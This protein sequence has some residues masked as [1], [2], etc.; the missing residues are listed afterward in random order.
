[1]AGVEEIHVA[2]A[3][4]SG[5]G[6]DLS[7]LPQAIDRGDFPF[8]S[9]GAL[10]ALLHPAPQITGSRLLDDRF[11]VPQHSVDAAIG[12]N[13]HHRIVRRVTYSMIR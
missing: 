10:A 12:E 8:C 7:F 6:P 9:D 5:S 13:W 11:N 3:V 1:M 4:T 2:E